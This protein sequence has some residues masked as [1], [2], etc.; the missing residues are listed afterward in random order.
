MIQHFKDFDAAMSE[1]QKLLR[2]AI[3]KGSEGEAKLLRFRL[4]Y[5]EN[6]RDMLDTPENPF[7][8]K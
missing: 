7:F 3:D 1:N 2:N 5:M 8:N 4:Q 6:N